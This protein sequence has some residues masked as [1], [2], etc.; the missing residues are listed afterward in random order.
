MSLAPT[1]PT[2]TLF[3]AGLSFT[4]KLTQAAPA[5]GDGG[6]AEFEVQKE[7]YDESLFKEDGN[8]RNGKKV[9]KKIRKQP[10]VEKLLHETEKDLQ[11]EN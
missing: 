6:E 5:R 7:K 8:G 1:R 10:S 11:E 9:R 4:G 2:A 3:Y